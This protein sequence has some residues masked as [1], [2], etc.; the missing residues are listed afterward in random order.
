MSE[1]CS[2]TLKYPTQEGLI[3]YYVPLSQITKGL[4][5]RHMNLNKL[6]WVFGMKAASKQVIYQQLAFRTTKSSDIQNQDFS[7]DDE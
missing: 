7:T 4:R 3:K 5:M 6:K 1:S 2:F